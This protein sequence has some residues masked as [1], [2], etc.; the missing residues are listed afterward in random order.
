LLALKKNEASASFGVVSVLTGFR[1][2]KLVCRHADKCKNRQ[3]EAFRDETRRSPLL[4]FIDW[5][6]FKH[7][8]FVLS[9]FVVYTWEAAGAES[10][11]ESTSKGQE[12]VK[13]VEK[14]VGG[15][16]GKFGFF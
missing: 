6:L 4:F 1:G 12:R 16:K 10:C 11:R 13:Q 7:K 3:K 9:N 14:G 5:W 8:R 15:E 2:A